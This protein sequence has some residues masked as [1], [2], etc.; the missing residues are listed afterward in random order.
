[1]WGMYFWML[2]EQNSDIRTQIINLNEGIKTAF[3]HMESEN[4]TVSEQI[5]VKLHAIHSDVNIL[6]NEVALLKREQTAA[7]SSMKESAKKL[8]QVRFSDV[9]ESSTENK[10]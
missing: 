5:N 8:N 6:Q 7:I 3:N 10:E 9:K 1:M 4:A 2:V